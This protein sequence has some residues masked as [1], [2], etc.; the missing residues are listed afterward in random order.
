MNNQKIQIPY[1]IIMER[2]RKNSYKD[3]IEVY[4]VRR[5]ITFIYR[6]PRPYLS[7]IFKEMKELGLIEFNNLRMIRLL[8]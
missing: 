1:L 7:K 4:K 6:F 3:E 8:R 2:L 5:I